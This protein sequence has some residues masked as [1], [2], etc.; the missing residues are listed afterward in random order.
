MPTRL[1][2]SPIRTNSQKEGASTV[3]Y[4]WHCQSRLFEMP[5]ALRFSNPA[6][7]SIPGT[8]E[9][10]LNCLMHLRFRSGSSEQAVEY[11]KSRMA[12]IRSTLHK[13]VRR[14]RGPPKG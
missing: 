14:A 2:V 1:H 11:Q 8:G 12:L 13:E 3:I 7:P 10:A 9:L 5:D 6:P 4:F